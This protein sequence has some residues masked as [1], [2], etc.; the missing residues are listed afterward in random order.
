MMI[1]QENLAGY[2]GVVLRGNHRGNTRGNLKEN[3]KGYPRY[4]LSVILC[5]CKLRAC[6]R[7]LFDW[8][9]GMLQV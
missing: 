1:S 9:L 8:T 3:P 2:F 5:L 6:L 7:E 4:V